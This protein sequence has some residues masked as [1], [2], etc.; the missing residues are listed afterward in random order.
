M[1]ERIPRRVLTGDV[2][3]SKRPMLSYFELHSHHYFEI[4]INISG[5]GVQILNGTEYDLGRG[6]VT[7]LTTT[8]FHEVAHS[9]DVYTYNISFNENCISEHITDR[10][11]NISG[12]ISF[13]AD[14]D[15]YDKLIHLAELIRTDDRRDEEYSR[16]LLDCLVMRILRNFSSDKKTAPV[17]SDA[18]IHKAVTY[19]LIHFRETLTLDA[20]A[21]YVNLNKSYF[22]KAFSRE[23]GTTPMNYL[24][25][26][27]LDYAKKLLLSSGLTVTEICFA[28]G[29]SSL[30]NFLKA[31]KGRFGMSPSNIR[32]KQ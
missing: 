9:D 14:D 29:Y 22:C 10:L 30:S 1:S 8:D 16:N 6:W 20:V 19:M 26:L 21:A 17:T 23:I 27:R 3:V 5:N 12:N 11:M 28:C 32:C 2:E 18:L 7:L 13:K 4:E 24:S 25:E 31:F 15:E